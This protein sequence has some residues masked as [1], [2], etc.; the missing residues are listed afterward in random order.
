MR[1]LVQDEDAVG[2]VREERFRPRHRVACPIG[3]E[4]DVVEIGCARRAAARRAGRRRAATTLVGM[5]CRM[6]E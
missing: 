1:A 3:M 5:S 2:E 6:C 4:P